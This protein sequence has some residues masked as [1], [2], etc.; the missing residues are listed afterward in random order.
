MSVGIGQTTKRLVFSL[1]LLLA[2]CTY[3]MHGAP[4]SSVRAIVYTIVKYKV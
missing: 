1:F 4:G 3:V 2:I